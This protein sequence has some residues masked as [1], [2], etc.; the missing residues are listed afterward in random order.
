MAP[1]VTPVVNLCKGSTPT[2]LT[3]QGYD[4]NVLKWYTVATGG[5]ASLVAPSPLTTTAPSTKLYYVSQ[6]FSNGIEGPRALIT[7]NVV[8]LP[9]TPGIITGTAAQ[10]ALVGTTTTATYSIAAVV[11]AT[12]YVWTAPTGVT[13][14]SGQGSNSVTVNF[15]D[16]PA[17]AGAIGSISAQSVN[18][19][20]CLSA[21]KSLALTKALPAAPSAV[22]MTIGSSTTAITSFGQYMGTNTVLTLTATAVATA[23]SYEW[24]L[25][26][27]VT[28]LSG[29]TTNVITVNFAG[30]TNSNT[31]SYMTTAATPVLTY[32]L[33]IGAKSKNGVGTSVTSNAT[34][35]NP[36]ST[37]TAKLLTL[38]AVKPSVVSTVAGQITG[39]CGGSTY[40]YTITAPTQASAYKIVGPTGSIVTSSSTTN[41]DNT[42]TTSDLTFSVQYPS[43]FVITAATPAADKTIFLTSSNGVGDC[44]TTKALVI[45]SSVSAIGI[46]TGSGG[47]TTFTRCATQSFT[48]PAVVGATQYTWGVSDGAVIASGQGTNSIVVNFSAVLSTVATTK[49]TVL[50]KNSCNVSSAIKTIT[51]TS[52]ACGSA[53]AN[54][55]VEV[56]STLSEIYPNPSSDSF[57]LD[58][59]SVTNSEIEMVIYTLNGSV[60]MSKKLQLTEGSTTIN[61]NISALSNGIY[62]VKFND[63]TSNTTST[64]KLIKN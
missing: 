56:K 12:S 36:T 15:N 47:I 59:N 33:R 46:A 14:I 53:K 63:A 1:T 22:K 64:R 17:G 4:G 55:I 21:A 16:V 37:S 13:I 27:G 8:A 5:T 31:F 38:K 60:V 26:T 6:V 25:P 39:V 52:T 7:V 24:E 48:V 41:A 35:T 61:E 49:I 58:V 9:T 40:S 62:I 45:A 43:V 19:S 11:G 10:G 30:V 42:L 3:A 34:A 29:G 20:G 23:T 54:S 44:L 28:K 50:A 32:V 18:A 51:L 2:E 57:N